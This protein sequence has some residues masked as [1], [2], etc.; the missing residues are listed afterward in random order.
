MDKKGVAPAY[1]TYNNKKININDYCYMLAKIIRSHTDKSKFIFADKFN[2]V[3]SPITIVG[4]KKAI[5]LKD[6]LKASK[7]LKKYITKYKKLPATIKVAGI[8]MTLSEYLYLSSKYTV[9]INKKILSAIKYK[10]FTKKVKTSKKRV[11][12]TFKKSKYLSLAKKIINFMN[13]NNIAPSTMRVS[14]GTMQFKTM[15]YSYACI[16]SFYNSK[17]RLPNSIY[18]YDKKVFK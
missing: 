17:K 14:L 1:I 3:K 11:R 7:S 13:K 16:L 5:T 10:K 12:G 9:N 2:V 15:V 4:N 8:K 6:V 18:L